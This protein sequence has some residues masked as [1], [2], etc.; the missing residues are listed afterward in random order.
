MGKHDETKGFKVY[1]SREQLVI[2]TQHVKNVETMG[3]DGNCQLQK[4]LRRKDPNLRQVMEER[5]KATR[6]KG[7]IGISKRSYRRGALGKGNNVKNKPLLKKDDVH[8]K[9][10]DAT[11]MTTR[12]MGAKHVPAGMVYLVEDPKYIQ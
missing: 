1:L 2:T 9:D 8:S 12:H 5:E 7:C 11:C 10:S 4:Q 3:I 6:G